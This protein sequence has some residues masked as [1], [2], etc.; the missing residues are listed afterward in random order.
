MMVHELELIQPPEQFLYYRGQ[1]TK[2]RLVD[3]PPDLLTHHL[4]LADW[5]PLVR[6]PLLN[7]KAYI[8]PEIVRILS[9]LLLRLPFIV[10]PDTGTT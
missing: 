10:D 8:F 5:Q 1:T 2:N 7:Y 4:E 6:A 3:S 9:R